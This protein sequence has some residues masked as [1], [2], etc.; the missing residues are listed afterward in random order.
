MIK[1][2]QQACGPAGVDLVWPPRGIRDTGPSIEQRNGVVWAE[3]LDAVHLLEAEAETHL[4]RGK[5]AQPTDDA[6]RQHAVEQL[7][8]DVADVFA[9]VEDEERIEVR[10]RPDRMI[11]AI[12]VEHD[13]EGPGDRR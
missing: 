7:T 11:G 5:H 6:E 4:A 8:D 10:Q 2:R 12:A 13:V 1:P 9:I 3:R